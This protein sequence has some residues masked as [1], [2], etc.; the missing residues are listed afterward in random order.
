MQ[1]STKKM[2]TQ[3]KKLKRPTGLSGLFLGLFL[4]NPGAIKSVLCVRA[5]VTDYLSNRSEDFHETRHE[6]GGKKCKK[7]STASFLRFLPFFLENCSFVR[8]KSHFGHF[9]QFFWDF[10]EN[11]FQGFSLNLAKMCQQNSSKR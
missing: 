8:T 1:K 6:V 5:S 3:Q 11:P 7:R 4:V 9:W 2:H 10:A